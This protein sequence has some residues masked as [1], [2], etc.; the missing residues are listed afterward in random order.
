MIWLLGCL[1]DFPQFPDADG[2]G[3]D[4]LDDCDD[5]DHTVFPG[6]YE[7]CDGKDNDCDG[8]IDEGTTG[9][10]TFY[11]D[12]DEDGWGDAEDTLVSCDPP[13]GYVELEGDCDDRDADVNP[14]APE[15]F[16]GRDDDCDGSHVEEPAQL[17]E[18]YEGR[19]AG[20]QGARLGATGTL[21]VHDL[22]SGPVVTMGSPATGDRGTLWVAGE[23]LVEDVVTSVSTVDV[24]G[25]DI[26][27]RPGYPLADSPDILGGEGND[28]LFIAGDGTFRRLY[29]VDHDDLG[30]G[31]NTGDHRSLVVLG[32]PQTTTTPRMSAAVV[33]DDELAVGL[34]WDQPDVWTYKTGLVSIFH[35]PF[36]DDVYTRQTWAATRIY[37][38]TSQQIGRSLTHG[39]LNGDGLSE[40]VVGAPG[41]DVSEVRGAVFV[42]DL[43]A[44][45]AS[46]EEASRITG[47]VDDHLGLDWSLPPTSDLDE[48]GRD[49]LVVLSPES[50]QVFVFTSRDLTESSIDAA[51]ADQ[52]LVGPVGFGTAFAVLEGHLVVGSPEE[53][54]VFLHDL[55]TGVG[56]EP[57]GELLG[58]E[59]TET[60]A[61]L[62]VG[63][64]DH[65][66]GQDLVVG[67]P[68]TEVSGAVG[69][70]V[71][72][73]T[74]W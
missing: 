46:V 33:F 74:G 47:G 51:D 12:Q 69:G 41:V 26:I 64:L 30:E 49:D 22:G 56:A 3:F 62:A 50:G 65:D 60:G 44:G 17:G 71:F 10:L 35:G 39:D 59:G 73:V 67:A 6:A 8:E 58:D 23:A 4:V 48:D 68:D 9:E 20:P 11:R 54:A 15:V 16:N 18:L 2:D 42:L 5:E 63:D 45:D 37:G 61:A 21:A 53:D 72:V 14:D 28:L 31:L 25:E 38:D 40:L 7:V 24:I 66:G 29:G 57:W 34:G 32:Y 19:L 1:T 36:E 13:F 43:A 70:A 52:V 55:F 27:H